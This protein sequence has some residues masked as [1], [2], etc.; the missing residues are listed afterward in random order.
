VLALFWGAVRTNDA[1][2]WGSL[3]RSSLSPPNL[4]SP[5]QRPRQSSSLGIGTALYELIKSSGEATQE[6]T[7][8]TAQLNLPHPPLNS[9]QVNQTYSQ[10]T[11]SPSGFCCSPTG[12]KK[13]MGHVVRLWRNSVLGEF[14]KILRQEVHRNI[15]RLFRHFITSA[16]L[17]R[18][19]SFVFECYIIKRQLPKSPSKLRLPS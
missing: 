19:P 8:D 11:F 16:G 10:S 4:S 6:N 17:A 2:E 9:G 5:G 12:S 15:V 7:S 18:C 13:G 14:Q 1:P 3:S